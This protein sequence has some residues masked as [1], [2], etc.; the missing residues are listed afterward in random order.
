MNRASVVL[1]DSDLYESAAQALEFLRDM[2]TDPA[3]LIM[4]DWN[5]FD[6]DDGRG[7]RL[8]LAEFLRAHAEWTAEPWFHYGTYGQVFILRQRPDGNPRA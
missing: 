2:L 4:D 5:A 6:R 8:A 1:L 3:I 7:E